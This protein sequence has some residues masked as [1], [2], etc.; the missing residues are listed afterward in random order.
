MPLQ[1]EPGWTLERRVYQRRQLNYLYF[2]HQ[3]PVKRLLSLANS[4]GRRSGFRRLGAPMP[5]IAPPPLP[6]AR[7]T[8]RRTTRLARNA[9]I[10]LQ[11]VPY[12]R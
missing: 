11:V 8:R 2:A 9:P 4:R 5:T 7:T 12:R 3:D 10:R 1:L 6:A